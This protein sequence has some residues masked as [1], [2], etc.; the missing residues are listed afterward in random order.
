MDNYQR[1]LVRAAGKAQKKTDKKKHRCLVPGCTATAIASH[2][3]QRGGQLN[4]ISHNGEVYAVEKNLYKA[5]KK[6]R[7]KHTS[8]FT[9]MPISKASIFPGFCSKHDS[10]VF[11][12]IERQPLAI[13]NLEQ[14]ALL[15]LR[16][17][18]FEYL[19]KKRI[20]LWNNYFLKD[21]GGKLSLDL[22][23]T[24]AA[25]MKGIHQF[26][27]YDASHYFEVLFSALIAKDFNYIES[28]WVEI[29]KNL[30]VSVSCCMSPLMHMHTS[31]M[32]A[33]HEKVQP[34]VS[35]SVVPN[36]NSTHVTVSWLK[37]DSHLAS[38]FHE[39][40]NDPSKVESLI[41]QCIF[42]ESEDTCI[43]PI[44]WEGLSE[45][46]RLSISKAV[47]FTR[48]LEVPAPLPRVV[49]L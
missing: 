4:A 25:K 43:S 46:E 44:L 27:T 17:H 41:N 3:Q 49:T 32:E 5:L 1:D 20:F 47:G 30:Q 42:G 7:P 36:S 19:Q 6:G 8:F 38:W 23:R 37:E 9:R 24:Y 40:I 11:K 34:A 28:S 35:F 15:F 13:G 16:A 29:P 31:Y 48:E 39:A 26:L 21:I 2:S 18:S 22:K 45:E 10:L 12:P 14:A 33:N